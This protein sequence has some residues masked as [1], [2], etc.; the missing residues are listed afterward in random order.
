LC[1]FVAGRHVKALNVLE[2]MLGD[3]QPLTLPQNF[4]QRALSGDPTKSS[5]MR[6][7]S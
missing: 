5:P 4:Y 1:L 7:L 3:V 2:F 6:A